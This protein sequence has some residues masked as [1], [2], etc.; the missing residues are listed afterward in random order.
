MQIISFTDANDIVFLATLDDGQYKLRMLWNDS[1]GFW[2][3]SVRQSDGT[4]LVEGIKVV[5]NYPLL[6]Q[7]HKPDVPPG[8]LL[9]I[10]TD[11][12]KITIGRDD[13]SGGS[14]SL[15]YV[16]EDEVDAI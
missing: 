16:T 6:R 1:G 3:L 15:V 9:A 7:Y 4:S 13:F 5:P 14:V 8:E 2:T 10:V 11:D 12:T